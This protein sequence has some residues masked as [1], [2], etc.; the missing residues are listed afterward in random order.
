MKQVLDF[1]ELADKRLTFDLRVYDAGIPEK[2]SDAVVIV[3]V[4][5]VN[6][7][8]PV[9]DQQM[10]TATV[11]ENA[12]AGTPLVTVNARDLD[13]GEFGRVT[14]SLEGRQHYIR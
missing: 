3:N 2:H 13:E 6:D 11:Q 12:E 9:F 7:E 4:K 1:E 8:S 10:Y 14:Y 5:N